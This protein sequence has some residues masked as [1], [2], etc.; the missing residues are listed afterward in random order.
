[1]PISPTRDYPNAFETYTL[2]PEPKTQAQKT[3]DPKP[4]NLPEILNPKTLKPFG[5]FE[6][7]L[8]DP[9]RGPLYSESRKVGTWV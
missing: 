1:M 2:S 6:G 8:I 5:S 7:T 9:V 3:L 4:L